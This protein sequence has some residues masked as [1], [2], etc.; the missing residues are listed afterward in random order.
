MV[1]D[2]NH[3]KYSNM[4]VRSSLT[5]VLEDMYCADEYGLWSDMHTDMKTK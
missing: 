3:K 4:G 5:L 2:R 1:D